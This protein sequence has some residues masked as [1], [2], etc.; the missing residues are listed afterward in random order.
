MIATQYID[1]GGSVTFVLKAVGL[2]KSVYYYRHGMGKK[3]IMP[4]T[5]TRTAAG[6]KVTNGQVIADI[7]TLLNDEFVDYGY[8]KVTHWLR[9]QKC[10][11]INFKKVYRLMKESNLLCQVIQRNRS[12]KQ[13][14]KYRIVKPEQPFELLE[15]DIKYIYIHHAAKNALL[16]TVIDVKSRLVMG[17]K[18]AWNMR[19]EDVKQVLAHIFAAYRTPEKVTVRN[20]NGSQFEANLVREYLLDAKVIQEFTRPATPEQNGH[21]ESYHSIVERSICKRYEMEGLG[22]ANKVFDRFVN[23]YNNDRIHSGIGYNSPVKYLK[24]LGVQINT[25]TQCN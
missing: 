20:D 7:E 14:V 23:F 16:F 19:K 24:S 2:P 22:F 5:H 15:F 9:Q 11:V 17:W 25:A 13:W 12:G 1:Q 10:Y 6:M 4:S 3:G 21:I 18:L 8:I